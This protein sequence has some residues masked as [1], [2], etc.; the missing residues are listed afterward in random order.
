MEKITSLWKNNLNAPCLYPIAFPSQEPVSGLSILAADV[1]GTKTNIALFRTSGEEIEM[2]NESTF[3]SQEYRSFIDI[4]HKFIEGKSLPDRL[5]IGVAGP[6][7][8]GKAS[9]TNL[10]WGIDR[11]ELKQKLNLD[12][13][14]VLNDLET[15]A[16]GLAALKDEDLLTLHAGEDDV[17]GNAAMIAPGTGLGEAGLYWDGNRFRP[18]ANEG[19]HSD[20]GVRMDIDIELFKYLRAQFGH[21]SWERVVSG[22]GVNTIYHFLKDIKK[23]EEPRWL[24]DAL[25]AGDPPA[26]ISEHAKKGVPICEE[27]MKL[28]VR[29]LAQEAANVSLKLKAVGGLLIGGGIVPKNLELLNMENFLSHFFRGGRLSP[30]LKA[31]PIRVILNPKTALL[32]AAYYG[33]F[34]QKNQ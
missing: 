13:V 23:R 1:G 31:I 19:G 20:F 29:Y 16:Y 25:Q 26:V 27:T 12:S 21:V 7:I 2:I 18:F 5:S 32:G 24:A 10:N 14:F 15:N 9:A 28:F 11:N 6:V 33:A 17:P 8:R 30:L 4:F 3:P 22:Q 34:G